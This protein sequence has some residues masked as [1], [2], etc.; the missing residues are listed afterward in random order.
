MT[1]DEGAR[2]AKVLNRAKGPADLGRG[3][4]D[5]RVR[6]Q[7]LQKAEEQLLAEKKIESVDQS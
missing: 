3:H 2:A 5:M 1:K 6:A 4:Q 7:Y